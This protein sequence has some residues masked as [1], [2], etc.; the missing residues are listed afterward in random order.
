MHEHC[1]F[2]SPHPTYLSYI[3]PLLVSKPV[4]MSEIHHTRLTLTTEKLPSD[5]RWI[6]EQAFS[7]N[8]LFPSFS[9][10]HCEG[11]TSKQS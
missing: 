9:V 2:S 7:A 6:S 1:G 10:V 8:T 4:P 3:G 5:N 11:Q